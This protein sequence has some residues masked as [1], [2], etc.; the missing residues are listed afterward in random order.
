MISVESLVRIA[1]ARSRAAGSPSAGRAAGSRRRTRGRPPARAPGSRRGSSPGTVASCSP[2]IADE[3]RDDR[4]RDGDRDD[5]PRLA[6]PA[7]ERHLLG[8]GLELRIGRGR[9]AGRQVG[10]DEARCAPGTAARGSRVGV[11]SIASDGT[12]S[13]V[14]PAIGRWSCRPGPSSALMRARPGRIRPL[15][16]SRLTRLGDRRPQPDDVGRPARHEL[17]RR[18]ARRATRPASTG[19]RRAPCTRR[20]P[21]APSARP[22]PRR[23]PAVLARERGRLLVAAADEPGVVD[24]DPVDERRQRRQPRIVAAASRGTGRTDAGCRPAR[25]ARGPRRWSP[26]PTARAATGALEEGR[27]QVAVRGLDL[28]ADDDGQPVGRR[29]AGAQRPVDPIVVA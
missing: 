19:R 26:R 24:L 9:E 4:Q 29:I 16:R 14:P 17:G 22:T 12:G 15:P 11:A 23:R 27:D 6:Q 10:A 7:R 28:L 1:H 8:V 18:A 25:P 5:R 2:L 13:P 21:R 3:G 20:R